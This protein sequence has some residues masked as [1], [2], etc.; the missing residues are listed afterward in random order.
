MDKLRQE[1]DEKGLLSHKHALAQIRLEKVCCPH[2]YIC[3]YVICT[4]VQYVCVHT[5]ECFVIMY[6]CVYIMHPC[7][8]LAMM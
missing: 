3:M 5:D 1:Q 8:W 2:V 4:C 7:M 6:M